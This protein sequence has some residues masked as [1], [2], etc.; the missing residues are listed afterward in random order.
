MEWHRLIRFL[1]V[2]EDLFLCEMEDFSA[3]DT[4]TDDNE[5][6]LLH[7]DNNKVEKGELQGRDTLTS[8]R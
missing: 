8:A 3:S 1:S 4:E 2:V 5:R 6:P 7:K